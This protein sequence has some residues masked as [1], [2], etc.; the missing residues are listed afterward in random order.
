MKSE[1]KLDGKEVKEFD[2]RVGHAIYKVVAAALFHN[3]G[4][5]VR[6]AVVERK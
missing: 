5:Y 2:S 1:V 4:L 6:E 3:A